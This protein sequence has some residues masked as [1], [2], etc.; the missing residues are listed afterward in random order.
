MLRALCVLAATA[1]SAGVGA[2]PLPD[3]DPILA[4]TKWV[5]TLSQRGSFRGGAPA[6][7]AFQAVLT[8]TRRHGDRFEAELD[9][10]AGPIRVT[11]VVKG[12]VTPA[13]VGQGHAVRFRSVGT[14]L[15]QSTVPVLDV[16]YDGVLRGR[17]LRGTWKAPGNGGT[18]VEG[19][20]ALEMGR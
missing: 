19:D 15:A 12:V 18:N 9:E 3:V 14:T 4:G 17:S 8:V 13:P 16:P 20:F 7:P 1:L 11:Y 5:G 6:P 2:T 10:V